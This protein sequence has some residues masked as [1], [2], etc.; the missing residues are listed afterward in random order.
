[1]NFK[2]P[3]FTQKDIELR[4]ENNTICV[5]ATREG[6]RRISELCVKLIEHPG[7]GHVH[8]EDSKMLTEASEKGVIAIFDKETVDRPV[9]RERPNVF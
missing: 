5:Y 3:D 6:L 2:S 8:L 1:M 7:Q 9:L 4:H